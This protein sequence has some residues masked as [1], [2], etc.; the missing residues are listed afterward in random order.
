[1]IKNFIKLTIASA[2]V[3]WL[4]K[5]DKLDFTL[6]IKSL[7]NPKT[8]FLSFV[9]I[10]SQCA[11]NAIR[12]K[13]ILATQT[14][15][16]ISSFFIIMV[17]WIGMFFNTALPGA[18]SGDLVK[19]IYINQID[20]KITKTS[21]FMTV[22]M[23]RVYGLIALILIT[24]LV[25]LSRLQYLMAINDNISKIIKGNM[26][27]LLGIFLFISTL[28]APKSIQDKIDLLFKKIP[29]IG[30]QISHI[31]EC[32]WALGR[33]KVVFYKSI[34]LSLIGQSLGL[35][36]FY[37]LSSP[38]IGQQLQVIDIFTFVPL[39]MMITAIP[40]APG[41]MGVG[42]IAFDQLFSY[43]NVSNGA[44]LFNLFWVTMLCINLLGVIPYMVLGRKKKLNSTESEKLSE[45]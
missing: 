6:I 42:H 35:T 34:G 25:S 2:L 40:L 39:G 32:F 45:I 20:E 41:G 27:L 15:E 18:V 29:K 19:M 5:N 31:V 33:E 17:N 37:I 44:D 23:D 3:Y 24:G 13:L 4:V 43:L 8:Y 9:L 11:I 21:M 38:Y 14:K 7:Q 28:F 10:L 22:L 30:N 1:M 12:W 16:K 36:A 26:F